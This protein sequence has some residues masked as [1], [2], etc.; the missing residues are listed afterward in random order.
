MD[1]R[2]QTRRQPSAAEPLQHLMMGLAALTCV[3]LSLLVHQFVLEDSPLLT[4]QMGTTDTPI[5]GSGSPPPSWTLDES[6]AN[7]SPVS[8]PVSDISAHVHATSADHPLQKSLAVVCLLALGLLGVALTLT[9]ARLPLRYLVQMRWK[10][11]LP[12]RTAVHL[13][14]LRP[15]ELSISRT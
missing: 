2:E 10:L 11:R 1:G 13:T 14:S 8:A 6:H 5:S 15:L 4:T 7:N 12:V 3:L 9:R